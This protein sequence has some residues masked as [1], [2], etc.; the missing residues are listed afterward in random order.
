MISQH[1]KNMIWTKGVLL[2]ATLLFAG[3]HVFL[4]VAGEPLVS[5]PSDLELA[6][7]VIR[8]VFVL[9]WFVSLVFTPLTSK[10]FTLLLVGSAGILVSMIMS[11]IQLYYQLSVQLN[12]LS[13]WEQMISVFCVTV[14]M[15][16]WSSERRKDDVS[17]RTLSAT[18]S[19]TGLYNTR[20]F[21]QELEDEIRRVR[22][23]GRELALVLIRV[24]HFREFN[25]KYGYSEGDRVLKG[26]GEAIMGYLRRSDLG[27]RFAANEFAI[28]LP[29]TP[30]AGA[31]LVGQ[32]F[33]DRLKHITFHSGDR[34][35]SMD[36]SI[37]VVQLQD[38]EA[39]QGF[40]LRAEK[41]LDE[42]T[43]QGGD[44]LLSSESTV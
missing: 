11:L 39:S 18:D 10:I 5:Q 30:E 42:A 33:Q 6:S 25:E 8:I 40:I 9:I 17:L 41:L 35:Y 1:E 16:L 31:R 4:G 24:D 44:L 14:G 27:C 21:H 37:A 13:Q 23:Y 28:L 29:E 7:V 19:L 34:H 26:L 43:A 12:N 36:F 3:W 32:R 15:I 38:E 22:R 20:Y 2:V